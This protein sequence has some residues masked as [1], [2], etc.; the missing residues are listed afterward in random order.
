MT[1]GFRL[2]PAKIPSACHRAERL[3]RSLHGN[4]DRQENAD[5]PEARRA[6]TRDQSEDCAQGDE[7]TDFESVPNC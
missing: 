5:V 2:S 4:G 1:F 6:T 3:V 7:T